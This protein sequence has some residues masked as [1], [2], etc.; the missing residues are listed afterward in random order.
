MNFKLFRI[1]FSSFTHMCPT[2]IIQTLTPNDHHYT[3]PASSP[4]PD[5]WS[6]PSNILDP[7]HLSFLQKIRSTS[8][9]EAKEA[10]QALVKLSVGLNK[11]RDI[12]ND[13][14]AR[15]GEILLGFL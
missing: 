4:N 1:R 2:Q 5:A 15:I 14:V 13:E 3:P 11:S 7:D 12:G 10:Y 8:S 9:T 6:L